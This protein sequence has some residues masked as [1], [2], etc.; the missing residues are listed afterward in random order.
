MHRKQ[1][2]AAALTNAASGLYSFFTKERNAAIQ[3]IVTIVVVMAA[4]VLS[5]EPMQWVLVLVCCGGVL[6]LEMINSAIERLCDLVHEDYHPVIKQVKDISAAAVLCMSLISV[7]IGT[8]I[9]LPK[10]MQLL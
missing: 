7:L 6:S 3:G 2:F 8:I 5:I 10:I 9:F 1:T 4:L